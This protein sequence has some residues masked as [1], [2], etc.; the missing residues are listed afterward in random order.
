MKKLIFT[1]WVSGEKPTFDEY[2]E[3]LIENKR[4]YAESIGADY[5]L[6][7]DDM[8]EWCDSTYNAINI[9][10]LSYFEEQAENYDV[11]LHLDMDVIVDTDR[12][13]FEENDLTDRIFAKAM[14]TEKMAKGLDANERSPSTK[15]MMGAYFGLEIDVI[16][17]GVVAM[18]SVMAKKL[19]ITENFIKYKNELQ[20]KT[21]PKISE[22]WYKL[23]ND[24][25]EAY[26]GILLKQK[27]VEYYHDDFW[28]SIRDDLPTQ[29]GEEGFKHYINKCFWHHYKD[30]T[31]CIY[32]MYV[33]IPEDK[34]DEAGAYT[35]DTIDKS[36]RTKLQMNKYYDRLL[37]NQTAYAEKVGADYFHFTYDDE[38]KAFGERC[39]AVVPDMSEYN[40]VN[41]Y[42]IWKLDQLSKQYDFVLY[43]DFDVVAETDYNFFEWC[44]LNESIY[45][46]YEDNSE[47]ARLEK[48]DIWKDVINYRSPAAKYWN[49]HAMLTYDGFDPTNYA[50]NTGITGAS[51]KTMEQLDY[52][53]EFDDL[54]EFMDD[55][56]HNDDMY[57]PR[58]Q[59]SFGYDNE[60]VFSYRLVTNEVP[61]KLIGGS[62]LPWHCQITNEAYQEWDEVPEHF[63]FHFINKKFEWYF[64]ED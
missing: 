63:F 46:F 39:L 45:V 29:I 17:T 24:N 56:V 61:I 26:F 49:C 9:K 28:H 47:H 25:N 32:S 62:G 11:M 52:F 50:I 27:E 18:N 6:V 58:V 19:N 55:L 35:G 14:P 16:N 59:G 10:K 36:L 41:F 42:K 4:A 64:G 33:D 31:Y 8:P 51:R 1:V 54:L 7:T 2:L 22:D 60:T 30:K 13:F 34:L 57:P 12:D 21:N 20:L 40:V 43:L 53:G 44:N 38:Y 5:H 23:F 15:K 48:D 37:E 3:R